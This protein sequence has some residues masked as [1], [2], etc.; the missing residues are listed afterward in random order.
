V[1]FAPALASLAWERA[2][3]TLRL[4]TALADLDALWSTLES[5]GSDPYHDDRVPGVLRRLRQS[6]TTPRSSSRAT[7]AGCA[8]LV[9]A[10]VVS[11]VPVVVGM[12]TRYSVGIMCVMYD[13]RII[14]FRN[15]AIYL[16]QSD[17]TTSSIRPE[18]GAKPLRDAGKC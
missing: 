9:V 2:S 3:D 1:A 17:D 12:L 5:A 15:V 16:L 8:T 7:T 18:L 4:D 14:S 13:I 10:G 11:V 6:P